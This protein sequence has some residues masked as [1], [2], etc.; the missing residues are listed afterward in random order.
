M[1]LLPEIEREL[2]RAARGLPPVDQPITEP[3]T[4]G[5]LRR[6]VPS[7][8]GVLAVISVAAAVVIAGAALVLLHHSPSPRSV[9]PAGRFPG[10]PHTQPGRWGQGGDLCP[11]APP[12]RYLPRRVGCVSVRHADV[13]GDGRPDLILLDARL[14]A[15]RA[16]GQFTPAGFTLKVLRSSGGALTAQIAHPEKAPTIVSVAN[17][18]QRPGAEIFIQQTQISSGSYVSVYT[19]NGH[20]LRSA[21]GPHG[22]FANGGDSAQRYGFTC[23]SRGPARIIQH[24]FVLQGGG[25]SGRWQRTDTTY[26][27]VGATLRRVAKRTLQTHGYPPRD[28]TDAGC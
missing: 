24:T 23:P 15:R 10:A 17:V 16:K 4:T 22:G 5:R 25:E 3:R 26:R 6:R 21:G 19:F 2:L 18:N 14:G 28:L 20:R 13:D 12:N 9:A 1:S 8:G 11:L 27:W 7:V